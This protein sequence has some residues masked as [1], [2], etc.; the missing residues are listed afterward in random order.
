MKKFEKIILVSAIG[1]GYYLYTHGIG[2]TIENIS[3][4]TDDAMEN[5]AD[6]YVNL[7]MKMAE[8]NN[9]YESDGLTGYWSSLLTFFDDPI[10]KFN[11]F[12]YKRELEGKSFKYYD[13]KN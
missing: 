2:T 7:K 8:C 10:E 4:A 9:A 11:D 5:T 6:Y 13:N 3:E 12:M 1:I